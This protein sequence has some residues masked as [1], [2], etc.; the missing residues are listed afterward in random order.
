MKMG[1]VLSGRHLLY[2]FKH[3]ALL[4]WPMFL[5][6]TIVMVWNHISC[7]LFGHGLVFRGACTACCRATK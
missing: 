2:G 6:R 3:G 4:G 1:L 7:A 5:K